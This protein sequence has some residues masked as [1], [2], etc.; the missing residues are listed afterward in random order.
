MPTSIPPKEARVQEFLF[1]RH[2]IGLLLEGQFGRS[3]LQPI[4]K[5]VGN[6]KSLEP[7]AEEN[8]NFTL[9]SAICRFVRLILVAQDVADPFVDMIIMLEINHTA[10][11]ILVDERAM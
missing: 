6:G 4:A 5:C 7:G 1:V 9:A 3:V 10:V 8:H 11:P 2:E